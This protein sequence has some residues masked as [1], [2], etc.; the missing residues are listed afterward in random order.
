MDMPDITGYTLGEARRL[1]EAAGIGLASVT[2]TAPP[3]KKSSSYDDSFRVIRCKAVN[4]ECVEL[5]ICKDMN[6]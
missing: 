6:M 5:L 4:E 1:L 2:V 3:R